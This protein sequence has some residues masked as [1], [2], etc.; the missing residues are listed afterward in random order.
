MPLFAQRLVSKKK[1]R[2]RRDDFELDL[3]YIWPAPADGGDGLPPDGQPGRLITM[4]FPC[5]NGSPPGDSSYTMSEQEVGAHRLAGLDPGDG[6]RTARQGGTS[7]DGWFRNPMDQVQGFLEAYHADHYKVFN[8]CSE[9][10]YDH[11][12]FHGRVSRYPFADHNCPSPAMIHACCADAAAWLSADPSNIVAFHCKAG[13]GRAGMMSTCLLL[14]MGWCPTAREALDHYARTRT[15]NG[16]GVTIPSQIRYVEYYAT[17]LERQRSAL[18]REGAPLPRPGMNLALPLSSALLRIRAVGMGPFVAYSTYVRDRWGAGGEAGQPTLRAERLGADVWDSNDGWG[19]EASYELHPGV[20]GWSM[21]GP[22]RGA[23]VCGDVCFSLHPWGGSPSAS[24]P[25]HKAA[26]WLNTGMVAAQCERDEQ[27]SSNYEL[28][29][30]AVEPVGEDH[31]VAGSA[32]ASTYRIAVT[33]TGLDKAHKKNWAEDGDFVLWLEFDRL[34]APG[35][36][37]AAAAGGLCWDGDGDGDGD[38]PGPG[39]SP[40]PSPSVSSAPEARRK[41]NRGFGCCASRPAGA[42]R[43]RMPV[44]GGA[45]NGARPG[46][47]AVPEYR[48]T[49]EWVEPEP[50]PEPELEPQL[51]LEAEPEPT[52]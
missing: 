51:Q 41:P 39:P 34:D 49:T 10:W 23:V 7:V 30:T 36:S 20:T 52:K 13:K 9:R 25:K 45:A 15:H 12:N 14:H 19:S 16:K 1:K 24:T 5:E 18:A 46:M 38:G 28:G 43:V 32:S 47:A 42:E 50:E 3:S 2:L 48:F 44:A 6:T 35:D 31:Y 21:R 11:G 8:F 22:A 33:Q 27:R 40:S 26:F 29:C 4:G 17:L 37:D